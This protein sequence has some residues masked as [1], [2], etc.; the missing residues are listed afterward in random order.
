MAL[1][2]NIVSLVD[3]VPTLTICP[4]NVKKKLLDSQY[5]NSSKWMMYT[6]INQQHKISYILLKTMIKTAF[7]PFSQEVI[8]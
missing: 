5:K 8:A 1:Q 6:A 2:K 4:H 3:I 7:D